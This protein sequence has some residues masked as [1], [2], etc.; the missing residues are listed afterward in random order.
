M[1][2]SRIFQISKNKIPKE[3]Y[4]KANDFSYNHWFLHTVADCVSDDTDRHSD[5]LWLSESTPIVLSNDKESFTISANSLDKYF[6]PKYKEMQDVLQRLTEVGFETFA[7]NGD[8]IGATR[9]KTDIFNF[10]NAV[11][12]ERCFYVV[13]EVIDE[14]YWAPHPITLCDFLRR[15]EPG[16]T[17]HFG[18]VLD[19]HS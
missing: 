7:G 4:T 11:S 1:S 14:E 16:K 10:R 6:G 17:Y 18:A 12:D 3:G 13:N 9:F 5:I 15:V 8:V 19:Y 2:H